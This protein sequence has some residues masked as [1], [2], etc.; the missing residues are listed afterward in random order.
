MLGC[1]AITI[2]LDLGRNKYC[3]EETNLKL[4]I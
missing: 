3:A 4:G 2:Q 1:L